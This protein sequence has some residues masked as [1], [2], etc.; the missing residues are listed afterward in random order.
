M[1]QNN[2]DGDIHDA[3]ERVT[4]VMMQYYEMCTRELWFVAHDIDIDRGNRHVM[5]G[6]RVDKTSY[7]ENSESILIDG[8]IAPDL[9]DDGRIVEVKPSSDSSGGRLQLL[10]YLWYFKHKLGIET[11]GVLA[12]PRERTR[13]TVELTPDAEKQVETALH[14]IREI[15]TQDSPPAFEE[16]PYCGSCA[17][18]DFCQI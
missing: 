3:A 11:T 13:E 17:Y 2:R 6:T 15:I 1:T 12:A 18:R 4:G 7:A 5:R 14:G 16:K 8:T 10:Y 9:L